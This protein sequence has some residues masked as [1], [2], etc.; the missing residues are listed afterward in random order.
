MAYKL[1]RVIQA[2]ANALKASG[3]NSESID[4]KVAHYLVQY[5]TGGTLGRD[6]IRSHLRAIK[7][8]RAHEMRLKNAGFAQRGQSL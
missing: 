4:R 1:P 6:R 8:I 5:R 3:M 7:S 2:M